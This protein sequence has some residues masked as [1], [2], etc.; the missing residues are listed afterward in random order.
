M[1]RFVFNLLV[2][3]IPA[4]GAALW[5]NRLSVSS[6]DEWKLFVWFPVVP[7]AAWAVFIAIGIARDAT[8]HNLW[9]FELVAVG[10]IDHE[11][12]PGL[13][14]VAAMMHA[15]L[16]NVESFAGLIAAKT[17]ALVQ[18]GKDPCLLAIRCRGQAIWRERAQT[19]EKRLRHRCIVDDLPGVVAIRRRVIG[20][21]A[22]ETTTFGRSD[23]HGAFG[24]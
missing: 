7:L 10:Q 21:C 20:L 12:Q 1:L 18:P 2:F 8:S 24:R 9:P 15:V 4:V 6:R 19:L 5:S 16:M 17:N 22:S 11:R 3:S 13:H 23:M 14:S